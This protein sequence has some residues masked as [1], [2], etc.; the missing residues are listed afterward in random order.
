MTLR[1][2]VV[3]RVKSEA[4]TKL[5]GHEDGGQL[6][7]QLFNLPLPGVNALELLCVE[8]RIGALKHREGNEDVIAVCIDPDLGGSTPPLLDCRRG[9]VFDDVIAKLLGLEKSEPAGV[10]VC[11]SA[12]C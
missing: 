3:D 7:N 12:R 9:L 1:E 4:E 5:P 8:H 2:L 10:R 11:L 6:G